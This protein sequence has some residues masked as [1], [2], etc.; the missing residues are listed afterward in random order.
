MPASTVSNWSW[1][2]AAAYG[3]PKLLAVLRDSV[4]GGPTYEA[5]KMVGGVE[6]DAGGI[7]ILFPVRYAD[8]SVTVVGSDPLAS[9]LEP[10]SVTQSHTA[11]SY[12]WALLHG[13]VAIDLR[14]I[15]KVSDNPD[16]AALL[17]KRH[18]E[19]AV[20]SFKNR[21]NTA[22][23]GTGVGSQTDHGGLGYYLDGAST[24]SV[25]NISKANTWWRTPQQA[26]AGTISID[27]LDSW[28]TTSQAFSGEYP[29][30]IISTPAIISKIR[31]LL[32][33]GERVINKGGSDMDFGPQMVTY[34]GAVLVAD[35]ACAGG[36][37][38]I[39]NTNS[40]R[41]FQDRNEPA[42]EPVPTMKAVKLYRCTWF[43]QLV[44]G[45]LADSFRATGV[46]A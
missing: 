13:A 28:I 29:Q 26:T 20:R 6:Q 35:S 16:R 40:I 31:S 18:A 8:L 27:K 46:T 30:L 41:V 1:D 45:A 11:A 21:I 5:F 14:E 24:G 33:A 10:T 25:G 17:M 4:A 22:L 32:Q 43:S 2:Q 44:A 37:L 23:H 19:N 7:Q 38:Y 36:T 3:I 9:S 34:A 39:V 15:N 42:V 12:D